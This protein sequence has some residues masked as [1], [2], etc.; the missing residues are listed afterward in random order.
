MIK[1]T[2][3]YEFLHFVS[4]QIKTASFMEKGKVLKKTNLNT[5]VYMRDSKF[6]RKPRIVNLHA[7][8]GTYW[9]TFINE[10]CPDTYEMGLS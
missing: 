10:Y 2:S 5:N 8:K 4:L 7:L 6:T 1:L 9:V 3:F